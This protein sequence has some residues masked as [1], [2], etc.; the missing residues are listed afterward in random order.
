MGVFEYL[1][2]ILSVIMGLDVTHILSGI[3]KTIHHL[4]PS[5]S[6]MG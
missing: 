3:S 5:T 2:V 4:I 1:G 6:M